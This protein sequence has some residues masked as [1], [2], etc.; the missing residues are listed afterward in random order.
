MFTLPQRIGGQE[1]IFDKF[2]ESIFSDLKV[3]SIGNVMAI[4]TATNLLTVKPLVNERIVNNDGSVK[5]QEYPV[6]PD[7]PYVGGTPKIG[8][9]VLI[10][11]C[12]YDLSCLL[13]ATGVDTTGSPA[14]VNQEVLRSHSLSN[15]VAITGLGTSATGMSTDIAMQ[16][17]VQNVIGASGEWLWPIPSS[18]TISSPFGWRIHPIYGDRRFH[19]GIDI[20]ATS[21]S[22]ILA[23]KPGTVTVAVYSSSYGNYVIIRHENNISSLYAHMSALEVAAGQTV[24]QGQEIGL[25]GSTGWSTGPHCHFEVKIDGVLTDPASLF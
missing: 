12:D 16:A 7:T 4:D 19:S 11:Y 17:N 20:A 14:T 18:S 24:T 1:A 8:D 21:G 2:K 23:T 15:A 22:S 10:I 3:A 13:S 25:V 5:W 9:T 6:I